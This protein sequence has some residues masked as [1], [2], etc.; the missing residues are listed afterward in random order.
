MSYEEYLKAMQTAEDAGKAYYDKDDP[1]MT[2]AD[3]DRLMQSIKQAEAEHPEWVT[4][5]SPTQ[6]VGGD[7][8][9][10]DTKVRHPAQLQSLNDLFSLEDV[11]QW[12]QDIGCPKTSV[13]YKI[14]GLTT[15]VKLEGKKAVR[16][17][18][19]DAVRYECSHDVQDDAVEWN[20]KLTQAATRGD[21]FIG[22]IVTENAMYIGGI[23]KRVHI[24]A[25]AGLADEYSLYVRV[26]CYQ[27]VADFERINEELI[28]K[29]KK[30][31][32]NPRNGAAGALRVKD[33]TIT[34]TRGLKAFAFTIVQATG[35]NDVDESVLP[36]PM[37][38]ETQDLKLLEQL[39]FDT[40][41]AYEC[42]DIDEVMTAIDEIGKVRDSLSY[43]IDGAVIKTD[44]RSRQAELG[45]T[46][47]YPKHATAYKYEANE[48]NTV[49]REIVVQVGRTGVLTPVAV[50]DPVPLAGTMVSRATLHNQ[51]F[52]EQMHIGIGATVTVIKSGEIIPKVIA[53]PHPAETVFK[54]KKCP[55]CG[56]EAVEF[57]DENGVSSGVV[58]CPNLMCPAQRSRWIEFYCSKPVMNIV[59][60]GPSMV[61]KLIDAGL[62]QKPLDLYALK[63]K[64]EELTQLESVGEK[65]I[66]T[67]LANVEK[68]K[69]SPLPR[70]IK[71]LCMP[72]IGE[73]I[74]KALAAAY[75][76][77]DAIAE[78][79]E[80]EFLKLDG[81][82][83]ISAHVM[84]EF[85]HKP[86]TKTLIE[87]MKELGINTKSD[88]FGVEDTVKPLT[89]LTFVITGTLP[90]MSRDEAKA[91]I[92]ANGG[93]CSGSVSKKTS[94]LLAGSD[95]GSKLEKATTLG[96]PVL[97][98][99]TLR[100]MIGAK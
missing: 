60:L 79:S 54:I 78:A 12:Y 59:G 56:S 65:T 4:P 87:K 41:K 38:C 74:G 58:G 33:P 28:E 43:W 34:A 76:D 89:G 84:Y 63:D 57:T 20:C 86:E 64:Y 42:K 17:I 3:Y 81:V 99:D 11:R 83:D 67:M 77:L 9:L 55:V 30:P 7:A 93:K 50:F 8:I 70:V 92:E 19:N 75:P 85:F 82:A 5:K 71:S 6:H 51:G 62:I 88:N 24:P 100:K 95:A 40:V 14:D 72:G 94:Y 36:K 16:P 68:S 25:E 23:P 37:V 39:G 90:G 61:D 1:I 69:H 66:K 10:G 31:K 80:E 49:I 26:E 97:D 29:G 98:L 13:Q 45:V 53:V 18:E 35:W 48:A 52:I 44:D 47:K 15:L 22:E 32:A 27:P 96:V 46:A 73:H 91:F 2:D 21:G